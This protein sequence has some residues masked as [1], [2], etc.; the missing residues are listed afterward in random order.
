MLGFMSTITVTGLS[1]AKRLRAS[2]LLADMEQ[3]DIAAAIG[4][5]RQTVSG[6][7]QGRTEPSATYFVRWASVTG[8]SLEWLAEGV[9]VHGSE[10]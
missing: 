7:E 10:G 4:V 1:L 9:P 8:Q 2:R 3:S 5:S 6:W